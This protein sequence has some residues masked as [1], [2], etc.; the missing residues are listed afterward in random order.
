MDITEYETGAALKY[1]NTLNKPPIV[2][3]TINNDTKDPQIIP[4]IA[5]IS[6]IKE[7]LPKIPIEVINDKNK[8]IEKETIVSSHNSDDSYDDSNDED[9]D[10]DIDEDNNDN[11]GERDKKSGSSY[12]LLLGLSIFGIFTSLF[13]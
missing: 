3:N 9:H 6:D 12:I 13:N 4:K 8:K 2:K 7:E 10:E 5:P 11:S 1:K